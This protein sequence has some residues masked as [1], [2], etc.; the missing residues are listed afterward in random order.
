MGDTHK[1]EWSQGLSGTMR[2]ICYS[3]L[4]RRGFS[5][6]LGFWDFKGKEGNSQED[7]K[8]EWFINKCLLCHGKQWDTERNF[9][10]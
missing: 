7:E 10:K 9:N 5:V 8:R 3:E 6:T 4:R 1:Q 2:L